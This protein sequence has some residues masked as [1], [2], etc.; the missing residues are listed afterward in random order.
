M[1]H[2]LVLR[3]DAYLE[4]SSGT[5]NQTNNAPADYLKEAL[6]DAINSLKIDDMEG[7]A[8]RA[9]ADVKEANGDV[10][11]AMEAVSSWASANPSMSIKAK[12]ELQRLSQKNSFNP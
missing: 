9:V 6:Q 7:R 2:A 11:G 4:L 1:A 3:A 5:T 8:W 12:R 10:L